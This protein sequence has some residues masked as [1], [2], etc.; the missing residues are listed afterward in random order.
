MERPW[1]KPGSWF[2]HSSVLLI[3]PFC[4][5]VD[6]DSVWPKFTISENQVFAGSILRVCFFFLLQIIIVVPQNVKRD[7]ALDK[8]GQ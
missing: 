8:R 6:Q 7:V 4:T 5:R 3:V 2:A 1:V